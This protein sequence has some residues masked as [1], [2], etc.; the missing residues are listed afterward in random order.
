MTLAF[1]VQLALLGFYLALAVLFA[2][3]RVTWPMSLYY[4]GCIVKDA[5][6]FVLGWILAHRG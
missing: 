1:G 6:V 5:G 4:A 3:D 2:L